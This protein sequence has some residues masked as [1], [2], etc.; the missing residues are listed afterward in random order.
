M[1]RMATPMAAGARASGPGHAGQ[2]AVQLLGEV[3]TVRLAERRRSARLDPG[4]TQA[5]HEVA[6]VQDLADI[7]FRVQLAP[8]RPRWPFEAPAIASTLSRPI[9]ASAMMIVR[10]A[11]QKVWAGRNSG[12]SLLR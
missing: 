8:R 12:S 1:A 11:C 7:L 9:R 6:Q 5:I 4:R 10:R 2:Q 3:L